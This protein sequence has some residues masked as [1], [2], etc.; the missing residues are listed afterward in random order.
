MPVS[1]RPARGQLKCF[2]V[3]V[4]GFWSIAI[5]CVAANFS[6]GLELWVAWIR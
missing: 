6:R 3:L 5:G 1:H 2:C 4:F